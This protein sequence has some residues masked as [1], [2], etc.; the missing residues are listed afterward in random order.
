MKLRTEPVTRDDWGE[1]YAP[2]F[3]PRPD[4]LQ[5]Q[6]MCLE[7]KDHHESLGVDWPPCENDALNREFEF[8]LMRLSGALDDLTE[9]EMV[10]I[11]LET[12]PVLW[13]LAEFEFDG[14]PW[15]PRWYQEIF[16]RCTAV[17]RVARWGRR[18]GKS[19]CMIAL[20][21]WFARY[22]IGEEGSD[23][24]YHIQIFVNSEALAKK[25]WSEFMK[26]IRHGRTL[27]GMLDTKE[28]GKMIELTNNVTL[29]FNVLSD[30]QLGQDAHLM[31]F[32]EAAFYESDEAFSQAQAIRLSRPN[33]PV[34]MTSNSSGFRG[35]FYEYANQSTTYELHL[36]SYVNPDWDDEMEMFSRRNYN[37]FE[38]ETMILADWGTAESGVFS[39]A[40]IEKQ[41]GMYQ[42]S[43]EDC[44]EFKEPGKYRVLGN[45]WNEGE[46]GVHFVVVEFDAAPQED[47]WRTGKPL[48]KTIHKEVVAGH[49]Y[50][51]ER[52]VQTAFNILNRFHC[53][54]AFL[55]YG[56]GGNQNAQRLKLM[57]LKAGKQKLARKIHSVNMA[58]NLKVPDIGGGVQKK[59]AKNLI[60]TTCQ[61]LCESSQLAF[62][63]EE[64]VEDTNRDK[65]TNIIPQMRAFK[66]ERRDQSGRAVYSTDLEE[67]TLTAW[68][69]AVYGCVVN[70]TDMIVQRAPDIIRHAGT[71]KMPTEK[72]KEVKKK[73]KGEQKLGAVDDW[74]GGSK[75]NV[76]GGP[77]GTKLPGWS[78]KPGRTQGFDRGSGRSQW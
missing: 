48:F 34:I 54:A 1:R 28:K 76:F 29:H 37:Q 16:M 39:P 27:S 36:P 58:E 72:A 18:S 30:K 33:T 73:K 77:R 3:S 44:H 25:H 74:S 26:F 63:I 19:E 14:E 67:H 64:A 4:D 68:M 12:D 17:N 8:D 22:R 43:Y 62:P 2:N 41:L 13:C 53:D 7:C 57:L 78:R 61:I 21:L 69:L 59:R 52:A 5:S 70:K 24:A 31:W 56:G 38:Y 55:D 20:C 60:V 11:Q 71:E 49:E 32:D 51:H 42:Y 23:R 6:R 10:E 50:N 66:V 75:G 15:I 40:D 65:M 46:N 45:D 35:K 47:G 9:E